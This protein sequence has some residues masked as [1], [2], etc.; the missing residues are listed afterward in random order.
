MEI[1]IKD[2]LIEVILSRFGDLHQ[3]SL[4]KLWDM[5]IDKLGEIASMDSID[6][7]R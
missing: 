4:D 1:K 7:H 5:T 2:N 3:Y 6:L